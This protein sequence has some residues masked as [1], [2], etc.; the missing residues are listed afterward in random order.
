MRIGGEEILFDLKSK[1][2]MARKPNLKICLNHRKER[3]P[4]VLRRWDRGT[5][6]S[7][8]KGWYEEAV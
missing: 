2:I 3:W 7:D 1:T 5:A 6:K 4:R 8:G